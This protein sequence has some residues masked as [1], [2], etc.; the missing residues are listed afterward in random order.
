M[1]NL[2]IFKLEQPQDIPAASIS[3]SGFEVFCKQSESGIEIAIMDTIG[4]DGWGGGVSAESV[5]AMLR[6]DPGSDV[7]VRINSP[8]GLAYDGLQIYN[9]LANHE[10]HV[11]TINEGLAYSAASIVFMAGDRR[12]V[13][14]ASDF[15]IHR[16][17]GVAIGN[18][19]QMLAVA[20]FLENLDNHLIS[21]YTAAT[22]QSEAQIVAWLEGTTGGDMGTLFSGSEA[23]EA[24]FA[25]SMIEN[26]SRPK[27][28][29]GNLQAV[30]AR[31]ADRLLPTALAAR[32]EMI[33]TLLS[34]L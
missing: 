34:R 14:E 4:D 15:G 19:N 26:K 5:V 8:G 16:S 7:T 28:A 2:P 32:R 3:D 29:E 24:G 22:G 25:D 33:D 18:L 9:A 11:T 31:Q 17:H 13:H 20:Q 23:V 30:A 27:Q 21:I 12:I 6:K 10:G 1:R